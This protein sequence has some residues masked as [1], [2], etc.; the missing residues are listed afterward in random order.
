MCYLPNPRIERKVP[1]MRTIVILFHLDKLGSRVV[2]IDALACSVAGSVLTA[3][4][5]F[6]PT[7]T[8]AAYR[9]ISIMLQTIDTTGVAGLLFLCPHA[10]DPTRASRAIF[11]AKE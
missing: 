5:N 1:R 4:F 3:A 6:R 10:R 2:Q 9:K 8:P 7:N 11:V